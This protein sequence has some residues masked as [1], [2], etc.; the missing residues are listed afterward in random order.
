MPN[1]SLSQI[2]GLSTEEHVKL[3][4][5]AIAGDSEAFGILYDCYQPKIYRFALLRVGSREDAEDITHRVFMKAWENI[6][7]YEE[8]GVP[9]GGWLYR[10]ARN[11]IIDYYRTRKEEASIDS[12]DPEAFVAQHH[13]EADAENAI[14]L[15]RVHKALFAIKP[16]YKDVI[17]MRFVEEL[18]LKEVAHA[19]EKSE[20]A[21]KVMQHRA[22]GELRKLLVGGDNSYFA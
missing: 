9:F 13:P 3:T 15:A 1:E 18:S 10:I 20:G 7:K 17:V 8:R 16:E 2:D 11:D 6:G 22:I 14:Q 19:M 12:I 4:R 5:K 21:I